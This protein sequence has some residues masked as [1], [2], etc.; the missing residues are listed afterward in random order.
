MVTLRQST[1]LDGRSAPVKHPFT[2]ALTPC[3]LS[4][5]SSNRFYYCH[6]DVD[7]FPAVLK[8]PALIAWCVVL[9]VAISVV[10]DAFFAPAVGRIAQRLKLREDVAGATL[11]ALGGAAPDMFTQGAALIEE[12][13]PDLR[14]ALSEAVGAGLY[15]STFGK[16]LVVIAGLRHARNAGDAGVP[17]TG[18][19]VEPFPYLR[20]CITYL[21]LVCLGY[22]VTT[23]DVVSTPLAGAFVAI[24]VVY[25]LA[26]IYGQKW[27]EPLV[28]DALE[29]MVVPAGAQVMGGGPKMKGDD[30][31][32]L[33]AERRGDGGGK[34]KREDVEM[35]DF[36]A[37]ATAAN[38]ALRASAEEVELD[39]DTHLSKAQRRKKTGDGGEDDDTDG[40]DS[41]V[42]DIG[43]SLL[44]LDPSDSRGEKKPRMPTLHDDSAGF[45]SGTAKNLARW[46]YEQSGVAEDPDSVAA[47][48]SAPVQLAMALT[49][50]PVD[51]GRI[52]PPHLAA[53]AL[54]APLFFLSATGMLSEVMSNT[55][56]IA[57]LVVVIGGAWAWIAWV[58]P[59][60][61][62]NGANSNAVQALAFVQGILW[63]H[64]IADEIVGMF[65][66]AGRSAGVRES[67]LGGTVMAWGASAGDLAGMLAVARAGHTRMAITA[68]M[69]GPLCQLAMGTGLSMFILRMQGRVIQAHL[70]PN[71]VFM[72]IFGAGILSY[73]ALAMPAVHKF[74]FTQRTAAC[75]MVAY[76][77]AAVA[78]VALAIKS[79]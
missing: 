32:T 60:K 46:A 7:D 75:I 17:L 21:S 3:R 67:L 42:E 36:A 16:A 33:D 40:S 11:L 77:A 65:Q 9:F 27:L 31:A 71:M 74:V 12:A 22:V 4:V 47:K 30:N 38:G 28:G 29:C 57:G 50:C 34:E 72:M 79:D 56:L 35:A 51:K 62:I 69:A 44:P 43:A 20:D 48:I 25:V 70:A 49:M 53:V 45:W 63:M 23:Q 73:F 24:Y 41:D 66:A 13:S 6:E 64:L 55:W 19:A 78:F 8:L 37:K 68:S 26:V 10:A 59:R 18:V 2:D 58:A 61:G 1:P 39:G 52:S 5:V 15:V 54:A 14:L 76:C